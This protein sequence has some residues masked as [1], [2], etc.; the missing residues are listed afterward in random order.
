MKTG[1]SIRGV[2]FGYEDFVYRAPMK[3]GG[4]AVDRGT[5]LNVT[6]RVRNAAGVEAEGFG[7]MPLSNTWAFPSRVL[8]YDQT[9]GAMKELAGAIASITAGYPECAHPV[10]ISE[11][12][13]P[14]YLRAARDITGTM[15][16][17]Q[18]IP[19]LATLVVASA[20]DAALHDGFGKAYGI[21]CYHGYSA[22]WMDRDIGA[23]LGPEFRGEFIDRY[24]TAEP[25][26][27]MPLYH[28]VG[29]L[30]PIFDGDIERRIG[31]GLPETLGEWIHCDGL[32]HIKIKLN[33]DDIGWDSGRVI[34]V[35]RAA[36]EAQA[37]R[38][39]T[40]WFY[41][42]DFNE[43]CPNVEYLIEFLRRIEEHSAALFGR[44][45]YIEQPTARDLRAGGG[46]AMHE[47][48]KL[49]PVVIDES[50]V[51]LES[52]LTARA[53]GYSGVALKACKGQS[54]ALLMA[55]AAIKFN[56]FLCV[57]DLSCP[58]ASLI[59]SVGLA[60]RVNGVAA[61]EANSRQYVPVAN[62]PW[63]ARFP[64]IF[65]IRSGA[66]ETGQLTGLGLGAVEPFRRGPGA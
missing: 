16:L 57:Q 47:A 42:L 66:M 46:N 22:E 31:D 63:Q 28:L 50:L 19:K 10:S 32:T 58:G 49:K 37:R 34:A 53:L 14:L 33:G 17:A 26:P 5:L 51:D 52:L 12:L 15:G 9:I 40:E 43:R 11:E 41:S 45:Q 30:D 35:D 6:V 3:F 18:P 48:A 61:I 25:R 7:S 39:V 29:A 24:V 62:R 60:A 38:G 1:V 59:H 4:V 27:R 54:N 23:S 21:N 36:S 55:A 56:M 8:T 44:V 2:E 13:E 65:T 64:G 20:F